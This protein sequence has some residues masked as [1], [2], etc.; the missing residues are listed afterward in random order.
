MAAK[1]AT[2]SGISAAITAAAGKSEKKAKATAKKV[3]PK[4]KAKPK[5]EEKSAAE[6]TAEAKA[7][8]AKAVK[9]AATRAANAKAK[10]VETNEKF[11]GSLTEQFKVLKSA[12]GKTE[13]AFVGAKELVKA[14]HKAKVPRATIKQSI[15]DAGYSESHA[16]NTVSKIFTALGIVERKRTA[17]TPPSDEDNGKDKGSTVPDQCAVTNRTKDADLKEKINVFIFNLAGQDLAKA[18]SFALA[19]HNHFSKKVADASTPELDAT[20]TEG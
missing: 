18:K 8:K 9:A 12:E 3:A 10:Q 11:Q 2:P 14:A 17:P 6:L 15:V 5:A 1:K 7:K 16:G 20:G 19:A 13:E 4:S